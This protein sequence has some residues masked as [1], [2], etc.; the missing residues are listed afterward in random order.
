VT[1]GDVEPIRTS[2]AA[3]LVRRASSTIRN[4]INA[5]WVRVVG[6]SGRQILVDRG[7]VLRVDAALAAG[8]R[9]API[10]Q[11]DPSR[12]APG[13]VM[14]HIV[15]MDRGGLFGV[16]YEAHLA[17]RHAQKIEGVVVQAP[18]VADYRTLPLDDSP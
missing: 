2:D 12:S 8:E 11:P 14:I 10:A 4:W 13:P 1:P 17:H 7:D 6:K 9:P 16:Y 3:V 18:I 15:V 5:G